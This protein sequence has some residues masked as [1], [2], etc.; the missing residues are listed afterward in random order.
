[1]KKNICDEPIKTYTSVAD[2]I[3]Y[4]KN[5]TTYHN[6]DKT[7]PS[8]KIPN[9]PVQYINYETKHNLMDGYLACSNKKIY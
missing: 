5:K 8:T 2:K 6:Y 4:T 7:N 9:L 1:M 3:K